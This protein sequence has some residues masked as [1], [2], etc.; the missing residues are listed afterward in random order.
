MNFMRKIL[1]GLI[2]SAGFCAQ[3]AFQVEITFNNGAIRTLSN[4]SVESGRVILP[5]E[6]MAVP[7][8]QVQN[9]RFSFESLS[10]EDCKDLFKRAA[11]SE[12]TGR[13][14]AVLAEAG[15]AVELPGNMDVYLN[16]NLRS[17]FWTGQL[18]EAQRT[19]ETLQSKNSPLAPLAGL[20]HVLILMEQDQFDQAAAAF[21]QIQSP[22]DVSA[23]MSEY[24][25]GRLA[26]NIR[27]YETA[28]QH[29]SNILA[30]Y[31]RDP[32]WVPAAT[33]SE[34]RIYKRTGYLEAASNVVDELTVAYPDAW[35]GRQAGE[36]K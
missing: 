3:A 7:L 5:G 32:E 2:L 36:L 19:I 8:S 12:L 9:A 11:Y 13:T 17:S 20:Y 25:R 33:F 4:V 24:I 30:R 23:P 26:M 1:A 22:D 29:F 14:G 34:G 31:S 21:S 28:L 35:W 16:Y 6:N 15:S 18:D 27:E 10:I